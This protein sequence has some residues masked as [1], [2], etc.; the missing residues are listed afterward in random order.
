[1]TT[2]RS[3][4]CTHSVW[5]QSEAR[6]PAAPHFVQSTLFVT[7]FCSG[8]SQW[9]CSADPQFRHLKINTKAWE[10]NPLTLKSDWHLISLYNISPESHLRVMRIKEMITNWRSSWLL[11]KFSLSA[12]RKCIEN[13]KE[14]LH[15]D[16]KV[17]TSES[18]HPSM[19]HSKQLILSAASSSSHFVLLGLLC[20]AAICPESEKNKKMI[21]LLNS[22]IRIHPTILLDVT[23]HRN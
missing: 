5:M 14:I 21:C 1:M 22:L 9:R 7:F 4:C 6:W 18:H 12:L 11:Y 10:G 16:V 17:N 3:S 20:P 13:S 15:T 23:F 19:F 2:I 8:H